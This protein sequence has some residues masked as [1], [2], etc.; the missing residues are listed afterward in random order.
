MLARTDRT[1]NID[2]MD[3]MAPRRHIVMRAIPLL[4]VTAVRM[5][6][7]CQPERCR[8]WDSFRIFRTE[9]T[10]DV[11]ALLV[12]GVLPRMLSCLPSWRGYRSR[13]VP[14]ADASAKLAQ[15]NPKTVS[16]TTAVL[17]GPGNSDVNNSV[18]RIALQMEE[19]VMKAIISALVC[20]VGCGRH[21]G[22]SQRVRCEAVLRA[23]RRSSRRDPELLPTRRPQ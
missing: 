14:M 23:A 16:R 5:I 1:I 9:V 2:A 3:F 4:P 15:N 10:K 19:I 8:L 12:Q 22:S 13:F 20:L 7:T 21:C 11:Q 18:V 17:T 6:N